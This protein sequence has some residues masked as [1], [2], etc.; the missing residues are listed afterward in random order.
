MNSPSILGLYD[1]AENGCSYY[2]LINPYN[3]L[4]EMGYSYQWLPLSE[5]DQAGQAGKVVTASRFDIVSMLRP[6]VSLQDDA[7]QAV[8]LTEESVEVFRSLVEKIHRTGAIAGGDLDDDMWSVASHNPAS[9]VLDG[10][11]PERIAATLRELDFVT[12]STAHLAGRIAEVG[13]VDRSKI[14][15]VPN[16]VDFDLFDREDWLAEDGGEPLSMKKL[17]YLRLTGQKRGPIVIGLQGG[18]SHIEDWKIVA[19]ALKAAYERYGERLRFVIAG[20]HFDYLKEA[21]AEAD[22]SGHVVWQGWRP[23]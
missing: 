17:R 2:R 9:Q 6:M 23:L 11:I 20:A 3:Q 22:E 10:D 15:I 12:C 21:L 1:G 13:G 7:G 5:L 8:P 19:P 16:L 14:H 18:L 4:Y